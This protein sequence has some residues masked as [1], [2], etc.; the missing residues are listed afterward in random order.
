MAVGVF[1]FVLQLLVYVTEKSKNYSSLFSYYSWTDPFRESFL[2]CCRS[3]GDIYL[4]FLRSLLG[5]PGTMIPFCCTHTKK[6]KINVC[7]VRVS[8]LKQA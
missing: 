7:V 6:I 8:L 2:M 4:Q 3:R 1:P 5:T